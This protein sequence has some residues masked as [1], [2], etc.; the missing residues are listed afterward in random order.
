MTEEVEFEETATFFNDSIV[1]EFESSLSLRNLRFYAK[2]FIPAFCAVGIVGNCMALILIRTNY[3]LRKLTSNIY[4]STLSVCGCLFLFTV[5]CTWIDTN[6][7]ISLPLYNNSE[8]GCKLLTFMAHACDFICVWM[9]SW[10]SIDRCL[11]LHRPAFQ[12]ITVSKKFANCLV[13]A[14]IAASSIFYGFWCILFAGL[15]MSDYASYCGLSEKITFL[16][17]QMPVNLHVFFTAVDTVLCTVVP[18]LIVLIVNV[19][20]IIRYRKCMRIYADGNYRVRFH[21][22]NTLTTTV[23]TDR[24]PYDDTVT[25]KSSKKALLS[26]HSQTTNQ[27]STQSSIPGTSKRLKCSDL[28]LTRS[29]LIVT[30]TFVLLN[31]PNYAFRLWQEVFGTESP[32]FAFAFFLS[33]LLYYLHHAVLF[34]MYIFWSPQMKKQLFPTAMKL[35]ECYC[36]KTVPE[37]GHSNHSVQVY[38]R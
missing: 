30:S 31:V 1:E 4:L 20:S 36:F 22:Q 32:Y 12:R 33:F 18:S 10:T 28:Q 25:A 17:Y 26:Q 11:V 9:I 21:T 35:V 27:G 19:L 2:W 37:F 14:T 13:V 8:I 3:W 34:Y 5:L 29:L 24:T 15:E 7:G 23:P 38:K 16:D 6:T